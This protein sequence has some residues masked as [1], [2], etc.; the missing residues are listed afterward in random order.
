MTA[1]A[2]DVSTIPVWPS[3]TVRQRLGQLLG[4]EPLRG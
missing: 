1:S 4:L 2:F 3:A